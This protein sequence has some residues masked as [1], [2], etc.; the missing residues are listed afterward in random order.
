MQFVFLLS[1][2]PE[3]EFNFDVDLAQKNSEENPVF[4]VQYAH[5]RASSVIKQSCLSREI[6]S[7]FQE[8]KQKSFTGEQPEKFNKAEMTLFSESLV[9]LRLLDCNRKLNP[10]S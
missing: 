4:Y 1:K 9:S 10:T 5:A 8:S 6:V 3:T 7:L 2:K